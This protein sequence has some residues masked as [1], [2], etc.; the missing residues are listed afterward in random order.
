MFRDVDLRM[1]QGAWP[2]LAQ[3]QAVATGMTYR[4]TG[5]GNRGSN[6]I[7]AN[8]ITALL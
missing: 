5:G 8:Q 3:H 6:L 2:R 7:R 4:P 1:G